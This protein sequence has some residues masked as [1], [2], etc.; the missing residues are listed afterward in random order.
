MNI[1]FNI[2]RDMITGNFDEAKRYFFESLRRRELTQGKDHHG[3]G[4]T[5][6]NIG[7]MFDLMGD[8]E[9]ALKYYTEGEQF[10]NCHINKSAFYYLRFST[11][12]VLF[13]KQFA[14]LLSVIMLVH[15]RCLITFLC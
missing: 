6:N 3:V 11:F 15:T 14:F 10:V 8:H 5:K 1:T 7:L 12:S 13:V 4:A 2:V 9:Q